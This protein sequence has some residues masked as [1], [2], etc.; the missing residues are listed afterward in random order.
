MLAEPR[1]QASLPARFAKE[2]G[3]TM[4]D[5]QQNLLNVG[6]IEKLGAARKK[7]VD[8]LGQVIVGQSAVIE[9]L[10]IS[11]L[12]EGIASWRAFPDWPRR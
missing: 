8:Q 12:A 10:L 7:I 4:S 11:L 6:A 3:T 1:R 5:Q 9:E 2:R